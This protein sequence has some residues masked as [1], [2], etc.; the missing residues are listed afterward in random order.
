MASSSTSTCTTSVTCSSSDNLSTAS[1]SAC[2]SSAP[3]KGVCISCVELLL[4]VFFLAGVTASKYANIP[5][6]E[7]TPVNQVNTSVCCQGSK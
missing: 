5:S 7:I 1:T 2:T 4:N 6:Y 3:E